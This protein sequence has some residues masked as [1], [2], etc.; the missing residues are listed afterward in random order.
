MNERKNE[1][2]KLYTEKKYPLVLKDTFEGTKIA[3]LGAGQHVFRQRAE[4]SLKFLGIKEI[5]IYDPDA[6]KIH[7]DETKIDNVDFMKSGE[8][9]YIL[10]P[11]NFHAPQEL[12][13]LA[14]NIPFY[15]EKP[16]AISVLEI[17]KIDRAL[18]KT[19]SPSYYGDYYLFKSLGL[20]AL[21]GI[22]MPFKEHLKVEKDFN[23]NLRNAINSGKPLLKNL[24]RIE[25][26][27]LEGEGSAATI[28]GREWLGDLKQGGGMLFDLM[29]H[30]LNIINRLNV[31]ID[32]IN[33]VSL[34]V[35]TNERGKY[36]PIPTGNWQT[37]EDFAEANGKTKDGIP[38]K[39]VVGKYATKH[40]RY[41]L[42]E[43]E[44]GEKLK[45]SFT[46]DNQVEW[47]DKDGNV[48]GKIVLLSDPYMLVMAD[49]ADHLTIG[50]GPKFYETQRDSVIIIDKMHK[51]G[52]EGKL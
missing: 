1:S 9:A 17:D 29:V 18:K 25:G 49:A 47:I 36:I 41:I 8:I 2:S 6:T 48:K 7:A 44:T 42:L 15:V 34:G 3:V 26:Y 32:I 51:I 31:P 10:S 22:E 28:E 21:M 50:K 12:N 52:R 19:K 33:K 40:N 30:P 37:A 11:N 35:R 45:L 39:L 43:D 14:Q 5:S 23:N 38:V 46:V 27:L 13:F 4:P 16:I 20:F 24:V